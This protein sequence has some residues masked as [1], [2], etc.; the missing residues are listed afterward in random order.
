MLVVD[1]HAHLVGIDRDRNGCIVSKT[2]ERKL[3]TRV[4]LKTIG[5]SLSE[6]PADVDRKFVDFLHRQLDQA[7]S[8]DRVVLFAFDGVYKDDGTID[9]S[10]THLVVPNDY[11]FRIAET[12][13]KLW[14][15]AS[16]N[17]YRRDALEELERCAARGAV[18][19]KWIP[20]TQGFDPGDER[21]RPFYAKLRELG[22][23]LLSHVGTEFSLPTIERRFGAL[24]RL[25]RALEAGVTTIIPHAG[26]LKLVRD[27]PDFDRFCALFEKH[28]NA[29]M[30]ESAL[31]LVHRRRRLF[32]LLERTQIH[33][34]VLHGSDFPLPVHAWAFATKIGFKESRRIGEIESVF[35]RDV[36]LKRALGA[37]ET[38]FTRACRALRVPE[39]D[40]ALVSQNA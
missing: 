33:G 6:P 1:T 23:P 19:V 18:L 14:V 29:L 15:G 26:N 5:A 4:V 13:R 39:R 10:R 36:V 17:P 22:L 24:E 7:P 25:E 34:R 12:H 9:E 28:P 16:V 40:R 2:M 31:A 35:E 30:D 32:R 11:A 37:P 3:S 8:V 27:A 38:F 20:A 21:L